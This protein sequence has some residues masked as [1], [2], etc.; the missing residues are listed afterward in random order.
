[1]A[2]GGQH[3]QVRATPKQAEAKRSPWALWL[4]DSDGTTIFTARWGCVAARL[5]TGTAEL[6]FSAGGLILFSAG[7]GSAEGRA[8]CQARDGETLLPHLKTQ[9]RAPGRLQSKAGAQ[10]KAGIF[11][12]GFCSLHP[13]RGKNTF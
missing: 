11:G 4:A 7:E 10:V 5:G 12:A 8:M 1:M 6:S 2:P 3:G 13:A 9:V